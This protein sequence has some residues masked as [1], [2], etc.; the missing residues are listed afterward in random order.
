[1]DGGE[2]KGGVDGGEIKGGVD[3]GEIKG[4]V[5]GGEIKGGVDGGEIEGGVLLKASRCACTVRWSLCFP[6]QAPQGQGMRRTRLAGG[7]LVPEY[8]DM[9]NIDVTTLAGDN[10][11]NKSFI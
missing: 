4:G 10:E 1:M 8:K 11:A 3:G 7:G 5:D 9:R 6:K 2:I